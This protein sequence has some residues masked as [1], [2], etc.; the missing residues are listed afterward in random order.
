[1]GGT[2]RSDDDWM[3]P[4][5]NAN[6]SLQLATE[7]GCTDNAHLDCMRELKAE[8]LLKASQHLRFA[9]SLAT[10]GV[11]PLGQIRRGQWNKVS[12][13]HATPRHVSGGHRPRRTAT[14]ECVLCHRLTLHRAPTDTT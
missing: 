7:L 3:S 8:T 2:V 14:H 4:G 12:P 13:R 10:E 11:F 1:M 6:N 5:L 9:P